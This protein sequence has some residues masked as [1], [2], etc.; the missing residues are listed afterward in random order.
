[1]PC[2]CGLHERKLSEEK[3]GAT[4]VTSNDDVDKDEEKVDQSVMPLGGVVDFNSKD[5]ENSDLEIRS[6]VA[7]VMGCRRD[8]HDVRTILKDK[9]HVSSKRACDQSFLEIQAEEKRRKV[10]SEVNTRLSGGPVEEESEASKSAPFPE[11]THETILHGHGGPVLTITGH[12]SDVFL[13]GGMDHE[14]H[15][16]DL[17]R[18]DPTKLTPSHSFEPAPGCS[19]KQ[20]QRLRMT[21]SL[22]GRPLVDFKAGNPYYDYI[23]D[24][25]GHIASLTAAFWHPRKSGWCYTA[26]GDGTVRLWDVRSCHVGDVSSF[27]ASPEQHKVP[28]PCAVPSDVGGV[29]AMTSEG[30]IVMWDDRVGKRNRILTDAEKPEITIK[31]A[32]LNVDASGLPC[33][34]AYLDRK[35]LIVS[36][37]GGMDKTVKVWDVRRTDKPVK[38]FENVDCSSFGSAICFS[39]DGN[40]FA[41]G[42][43]V[44]SSSSARSKKKRKEER[45]EVNIFDSSRL[46]NLQSLHIT[47]GPVVSLYWDATS[48]NLLAG[49][50]GGKIHVLQKGDGGI[51]TIPGLQLQPLSTE[52][53]PSAPVH[54]QNDYSGVDLIELQLIKRTLREE[55]EEA[56][57][58]STR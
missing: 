17:R 11:F 42:S 22:P 44:F 10:A 54:F 5:S 35:R 48:N 16:F 25:A 19:V 34:L 55:R 18:V 33:A 32:H 9:E 46:V 45:G 49:S 24:T 6:T 37:G 20:I 3:A 50:T 39:P 31:D 36:Q 58:G 30:N 12:K 29:L 27:A 56:M 8:F 40:F 52:A 43:R 51:H 21:K 4:K 47:S 13:S 41:V 26:A 28:I 7:R 14:I 15:T 2:G 23:E 38:I 1:M 57:P 53:S